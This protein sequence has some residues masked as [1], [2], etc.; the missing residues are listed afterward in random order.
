MPVAWQYETE[1][2]PERSGA[3]SFAR[4]GPPWVTACLWPHRSLPLRGFAWFIMVTYALSLVPLFALLGTRVLWGLLPFVLGALALV[5]Y[6]IRRSYA[7]GALREDLAIWTDRIE[8]RRT[9]PDG[10][11]QEWS[12]NPYWVQV[13]I[14]HAGGPVQDYVTLKGDTRQVEIGA[15]LSPEERHALYGD[16]RRA[17]RRLPHGPGD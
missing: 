11:R 17:L 1:K 13:E 16:L 3:F 12:A 10:S 9:A 14:H 5:W 4:G 2:A 7:D 6:F 15:F 8:L